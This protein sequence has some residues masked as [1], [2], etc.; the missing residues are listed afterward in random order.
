MLSLYCKFTV[1]HMVLY[2]ILELLLPFARTMLTV[3][4]EIIL[5]AY[6]IIRYVTSW[7]SYK[8]NR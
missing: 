5:F 8:L 4:Y 3:Y 1:C 2:S 6:C 7:I